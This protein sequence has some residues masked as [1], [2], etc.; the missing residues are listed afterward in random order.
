MYVS[1]SSGPFQATLLSLIEAMRS[2]AVAGTRIRSGDSPAGRVG[3][4]AAIMVDKVT[5][6]IWER[7]ACFFLLSRWVKYRISL[8][9]DATQAVFL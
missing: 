2:E 9:V 8:A 5:W 7:E 3:G 4:S 6:S 1:T